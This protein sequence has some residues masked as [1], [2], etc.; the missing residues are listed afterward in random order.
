[1]TNGRAGVVVE[2]G[3]SSG[4]ER[5]GWALPQPRSMPEAGAVGVTS[6]AGTRLMGRNAREKG[7]GGGGSYFV[8]AR[9][10]FIMAQRGICAGL[11]CHRDIYC[12]TKR[13]I[14]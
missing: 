12:Q 10:G 5:C 1:M 2:I 13:T 6:P 14:K 11:I 9:Q 7:R 3:A 4:A 8:M